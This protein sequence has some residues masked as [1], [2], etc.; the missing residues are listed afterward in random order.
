MAVLRLA[1][2]NGGVPHLKISHM[3]KCFFG[4]ILTPSHA[5][6]LAAVETVGDN[7]YESTLLV[8]PFGMTELFNNE[9][10]WLDKSSRLYDLGETR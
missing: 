7:V 6:L 10:F 2:A 9:S 8:L 3:S 1:A 4:T 5:R